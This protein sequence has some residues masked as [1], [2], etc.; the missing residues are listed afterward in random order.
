MLRASVAI[1]ARFL[2]GVVWYISCI[3]RA[4]VGYILSREVT[5]VVA[6]AIT[7][8]TER[9]SGRWF[10]LRAQASVVRILHLRI[11]GSSRAA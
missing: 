10:W 1:T 3:C 8:W 6:V 2:R 5:I 4:A 11:N 7:L 9:R